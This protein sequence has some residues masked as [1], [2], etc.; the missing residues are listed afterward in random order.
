[1]KKLLKILT[2]IFIL[3]LS[4]F[5][6]TACSGDNNDGG[7]TPPSH[8]HEYSTEY[9]Y[10]NDYHWY[11]CECGEKS[12]V[13]NHSGGTPTCTVLAECSVCGEGYGEYS[14]H[15]YEKGKCACGATDPT[16]MTEGLVFSLVNNE[17]EYEVS[18]YTGASTEVI[19]PAIYKGKIVSSIGSF[20]FNSCFSLKCVI[21]PNS[22]TNI[23]FAAF[24]CCY[25][26]DEILIPNSVKSLGSYAFS[27][28]ISLID[29]IIPNG[30][31]I[32]DDGTFLGCTSLINIDIP[33]SVTNIGRCAFGEC[34]KMKSI[35]IPSSVTTV[36]DRAFI[37]CKLLKNIVIP[38]S[39]TNIAD[40]VFQGCDSLT[41]I[42]CEAESKPSGW[43]SDWKE[44]CSAQVIWG[45]KKEN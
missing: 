36:G 4:A 7:E 10:D 44:G 38:N 40:C 39:I 42:Y 17:T 12:N 25:E 26:L 13:E 34:Y 43:D 8:T 1:M 21:M 32:I 45:Y 16:Y 35:E 3:S 18:D 2:L 33:N 9:T 14:D 19:V 5:I 30:I 28:C 37:D 24:A 41:T 27:E 15:I 31:S 20:A 23:G 11:E 29:I 6:L 22:I